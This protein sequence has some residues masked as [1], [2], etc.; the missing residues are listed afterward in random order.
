MLN[1]SPLINEN[2][3]ASRQWI[4]RMGDHLSPYKY[5]RNSSPYGTNPTEHLLKSGRRPPD[6]QKGKP[7]SLEEGRSK[8][9][10]KNRDKGFQDGNLHFSEGVV[11]EVKFPH[12]S[13]PLRV[14]GG[15][16]F[17]T[18]EGVQQQMLRRQNGENSPQRSL[19][20]STSQKRSGSHACASSRE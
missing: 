13:S 5:I 18:S 16:S 20:N 12:I 10:D 4:N 11:R 14:G 9:E 3:E 17:G 7:I 15:G 1:I 6:F 2:V 8:D 19:W